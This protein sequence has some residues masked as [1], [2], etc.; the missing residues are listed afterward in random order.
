MTNSKIFFLDDN[1]DRTQSFLESYPEAYTVSTAQ[2]AIAALQGSF[3]DYVF[4]DH[5][6]GGEAWVDSSRPDT[7][8]EVVRWI[9]ENQ[10]QI[11]NI[12]VHSHNTV[13]APAMVDR[14]SRAGY[15][16]YAIPFR[17]VIKDYRGL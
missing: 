3:Y 7:G 17:T 9:M 8:M 11:S 14:L 10:P 13:A 15:N 5:D 4:L 6:L 2:A 12:V 1:P 16:A